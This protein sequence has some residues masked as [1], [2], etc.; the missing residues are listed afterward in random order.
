MVR[1]GVLSLVLFLVVAG[2]VRAEEPFEDLAFDKAC[3]KAAK[4]KKVVMIDFYTTWCGPC[5]MLDRNTWPN[6]D[7]KKLIKQHAVA[8]KV[9]AEK[10]RE[11]SAKYRINSY[12]QIVFLN[13]DGT[14]I[15]RLVG[16]RDAASFVR[17]AAGPISG[18]DS[19]AAMREEIAANPGDVMARLRFA[20]ALSQKG[21]PSEAL[22]EL[23]WL[24]DVGMKGKPEHVQMRT[25]FLVQKIAMLGRAVPET[26]K[27]LQERRQAAAHVLMTPPAKGTNGHSAADSSFELR[28][29]AMALANIDRITGSPNSTVT[30]LDEIKARGDSLDAARRMLADQIVDALWNVKRYDDYVTDGSEANAFLKEQVST[31]EENVKKYKLDARYQESMKQQIALRS[32]KYYEALIGVNKEAAARSFADQLLKFDGSGRAYATLITHATRV[33]RSDLAR[34]LA[35]QGLK[36]L[37]EADK[38]A[39]QR[40]MDSIPPTTDASKP[41]D[42]PKAS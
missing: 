5:K 20:D 14:E 4:E 2:P 30:L 19:I 34:G 9:D 12:P 32:A 33:G 27:L 21:K 42:K 39:V 16:Y 26:S 35:E 28:E 37:P 25:S 1:L 41:E 22:V 8:L 17:D 10:N 23:L 40:A 3:E 31:F 13:P 7:V 15:D 24:Y 36:V 18:K 29:A 11:L 6:D 38:A